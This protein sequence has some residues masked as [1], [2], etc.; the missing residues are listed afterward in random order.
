MIWRSVWYGEWNSVLWNEMWYVMC[1]VSVN[2]PIH[3]MRTH[4]ILLVRFYCECDINCSQFFI[5][6]GQSGMIFAVIRQISKH[7]MRENAHHNWCLECFFPY[8]V[9]FVYLC[10]SGVE[11][12]YV[13][14]VASL[15]LISHFS[16]HSNVQMS[17]HVLSQSFSH[18]RREWK[19][20]KINIC[21]NK[22][23]I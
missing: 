6:R 9:L 19:E 22:R 23:Y 1:G 13:K 17:V 4:S 18:K 12:I 5:A 3:K 11:N 7:H 20:N 8:L 2:G 14:I 10:R 15:K 21:N 16:K